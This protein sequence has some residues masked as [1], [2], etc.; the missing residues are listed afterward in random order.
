MNITC[1]CHVCSAPIEFDTTDSGKAVTCP[2]CGMDTVLFMP[3]ANKKAV[4]LAKS[5]TVDPPR[6]KK[7][8]HSAII[9]VVLFLVGFGLIFNGLSVEISKDVGAIHQVYAAAQYC[10]GF[11][12]V[13]LSLILNMLRNIANKQ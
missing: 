5:E 8:R 12:I 7:R 10:T 3:A 4:V 13:S 11:V 6:P 2:H 9:P 1:P